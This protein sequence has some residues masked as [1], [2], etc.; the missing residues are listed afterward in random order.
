VRSDVAPISKFLR[1]RGFNHVAGKE[2]KMAT[3]CIWARK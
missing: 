2:L 1:E 3:S